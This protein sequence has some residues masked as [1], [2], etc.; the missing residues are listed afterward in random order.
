MDG[1]DRALQYRRTMRTCH[2][3]L[4]NKPMTDDYPCSCPR[5]C[6][7]INPCVL[8][9]RLPSLRSQ[10]GRSHSPTAALTA[11]ADE[12]IPG[13][14]EGISASAGR[15]GRQ[16][17]TCT[18]RSLLV[19]PVCAAVRLLVEVST[20]AARSYPSPSGDWI[21]QPWRFAC[22]ATARAWRFAPG[23]VTGGGGSE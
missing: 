15:A 21:A 4:G 14:M 7:L 11:T 23:A 22:R 18:T 20:G 13:W 5:S 1:F 19:C 16:S 6:M 12:S 8:N 10:R 2:S 9:T 3:S 17:T